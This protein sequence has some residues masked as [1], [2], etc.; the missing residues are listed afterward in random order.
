MQ[1]AQLFE[2]TEE[3]DTVLAKLTKLNFLKWHSPSSKTK[4]VAHSRHYPNND[5]LRHDCTEL[6][7]LLIYSFIFVHSPEE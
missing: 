6:S 2:T 5:L 7:S 1:L 4:S 3:H